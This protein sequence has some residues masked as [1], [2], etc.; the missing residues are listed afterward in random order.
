MFMEV[1]SMQKIMSPVFPAGD[2]LLRLSVYQSM[3][4]ETDYLSMCLETKDSEK[5]AASDKTCWCL[6]R[7]SVLSHK[8]RGGQH[9]VRDSFGRFATDAASGDTTSLGWNDF[10]LMRDFLGPEE[11]HVS[12]DGTAVFC[13]SYHI[14]RESVTFVRSIERP[15]SSRRCRTAAGDPF[16][17]RFV[18]RIENFTKLKELLKKRKIA[19][20]CIKSKRFQVLA[21][22]LLLLALSSEA[23]VGSRACACCMGK[24]SHHHAAS[25]SR[26]VP[27]MLSR[28]PYQALCVWSSRALQVGGKDCRLIVYPRGQSQPPRHLSLFLE[29]TD[30]RQH[31]TDWSCFVSHRLSVV[32]QLKDSEK[33]RSVSKESQNRYSKVAKDWG[34]REFVTLTSLFDG[35]LGFLVNDTL[36]LCAEV[37]ALQATRAELACDCPFTMLVFSWLP[38]QGECAQ[39]GLPWQGMPHNAASSHNLTP[40]QMPLLPIMYCC[41]SPPHSPYSFIMRRAVRK[42]E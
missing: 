21:A 9:M 3:V 16:Q 42:D 35:D 6:F 20:L 10:M 30:P 32:N 23:S 28:V 27:T 38:L 31:E 5:G 17:G 33:D 39:G 34:W 26:H 37:R 8:E 2:C 40:Q 1:M 22:N 7:M 4:G 11:R 29:V 36:L 41:T 13:V 18:W 14:I 25:V 12:D 24:H 15:L 19:S